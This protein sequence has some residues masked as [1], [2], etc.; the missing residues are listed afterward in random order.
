MG[1]MSVSDRN[2]SAKHTTQ[3]ADLKAKV[4]LLQADLQILAAAVGALLRGSPITDEKLAEAI[5]SARD[6]EPFFP[7]PAGR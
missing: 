3:I 1:T 2:A 4:A 6:R 5:Q 7:K